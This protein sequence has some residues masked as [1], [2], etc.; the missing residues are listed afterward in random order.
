MTA[1]EAQELLVRD[2]YVQ[3]GV[4]RYERLSFNGAYRATG[5]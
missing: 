2:P 5:L 3:G 1:E 4:A